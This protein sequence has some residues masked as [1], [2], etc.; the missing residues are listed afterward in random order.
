MAV[1]I[2]KYGHQLTCLIGGL[3][4][5]SLISCKPQ[6]ELPYIVKTDSVTVQYDMEQIFDYFWVQGVAFIQIN[7]TPFLC[8]YRGDDRLL[9]ADVYDTAK[10]LAIPVAGNPEAFWGQGRTLSYIAK[11]DLATVQTI[12]FDNADYHQYVTGSYRIPALFNDSIFIS[13]IYLS[14]VMDVHNGLLIPYRVRNES[15]NLLDT[16]AYLYLKKGPAGF[17]HTK[18]I[19]NQE[20]LLQRYEYLRFPISVYDRSKE[21]L[22]YT[23]LKGDSLSSYS[24]KDGSTKSVALDPLHTRPFDAAPNNLTYL[25][26]YLKE[27]DKIERMIISPQGHIYLFI[28]N[29]KAADAKSTII[30]YNNELIQIAELKLNEPLDPSVA[31]IQN[32]KIHIY[33]ALSHWVFLSFSLAPS[34]ERLPE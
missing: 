21:V 13:S 27:N 23:F 32:E 16:F 6:P 7:D 30:V 8:M 25:R 26:R 33:K 17:E 3:F 22:Y 1:P 5:C 12:S 34:A 18:M 28:T 11:E 14:M 9:I 4:C 19:R 10:V 15:P 2:I 20:T 24:F 29:R 31:F